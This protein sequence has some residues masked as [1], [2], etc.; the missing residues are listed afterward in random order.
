M[1]LLC[2]SCIPIRNIFPYQGLLPSACS[3]SHGQFWG[4]IKCYEKPSPGSAGPERGT[5]LYLSDISC[6]LPTPCICV[7]SGSHRTAVFLL[8]WDVTGHFGSVPLQD[9]SIFKK[10]IIKKKRQSK[11]LVRKLWVWFRQQKAIIPKP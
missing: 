1:S 4:A 11:L 10:I 9:L 7:T 3:V 8:P 2:P 6:C 5:A